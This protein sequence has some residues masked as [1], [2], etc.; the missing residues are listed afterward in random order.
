[1]ADHLAV[2]NMLVEALRRSH[3]V[4]SFEPFTLL[5]YLA[6][7]TDHIGLVA[8]ASTTFDAPYHVARRARLDGLVHD[9]SS[10]SSLSIILGHDASG[11]GPDGPQPEIPETNAS[12][13]G[14]KRAIELA[15]RENLTCVS[16]RTASAASAGSRSWVRH[17][18][19]PTRWKRG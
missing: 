11:F 5:S 9:D 15:R 6:A 1:M 2:L 7:A 10:V 12:Q 4:T 16:W 18:A 17:R 3:T 8:T 13:S 14:R 19:S